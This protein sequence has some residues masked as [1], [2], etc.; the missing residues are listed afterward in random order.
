MIEVK[1]LTIKRGDRKIISE[2]SQ[3]FEAGKCYWI[4]GENGIGKSTLISAL[5]GDLPY[6][7][8]ITYNKIALQEI[9][10]RNRRKLRA[11]MA[12][13]LS[14]DFPITV[15]TAL[16]LVTSNKNES[17]EI[18]RTL[19]LSNLIDRKLT[20]LSKGQLQRVLLAQTFLQG[21][22]HL[23][24]DEPFSAQDETHIE[25]LI[26]ILH[27]EKKAGRTLIIASHMNLEPSGLV[28]QTLHLA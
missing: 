5:S 8:T 13:D 15:K 17:G 9:S 26:S 2:F 18:S 19:D 16:Q 22:S 14:I 27:S 23:L 11:V 21:S 1:N 24:L 12:Q 4:V 20:E 10:I 7:G 25:K 6:D 3:N 28:D